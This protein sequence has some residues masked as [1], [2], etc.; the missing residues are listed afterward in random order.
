MVAALRRAV[1]LAGLA[2]LLRVDLVARPRDGLTVLPR[3]DLVARPRVDPVDRPS[4]GDKR[5]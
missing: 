4:V 1:G 5:S 3:V 2:A